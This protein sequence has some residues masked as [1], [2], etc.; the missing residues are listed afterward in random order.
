MLFQEFLL[1]NMYVLHYLHQVQGCWSKFRFDKPGDCFEKKKTDDYQENLQ[2][3]PQFTF[4]VYIFFVL[5]EQ[6]AG[7]F[8]SHYLSPGAKSSQANFDLGYPLQHQKNTDCEYKD[9]KK[10]FSLVA[11]FKISVS[12]VKCKEQSMFQ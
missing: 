2:K 5:R 6:Q 1:W 10:K 7:F 12:F 9:R 4:P 8:K 3:I 11:C